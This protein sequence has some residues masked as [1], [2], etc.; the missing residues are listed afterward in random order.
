[1]SQ[2]CL[3]LNDT[4]AATELSNC[5]HITGRAYATFG[6]TINGLGGALTGANALDV[7]KIGI[8]QALLTSNI[9][10]LTDAYGRVGAELQIKNGI[11]VDGIRADGSFGSQHLSIIPWRLWSS[12]SIF[13][14]GQHGGIIYNGN[15]GMSPLAAQWDQIGIPTILRSTGKD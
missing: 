11:K 7:S 15:Y 6:E 8:D 9:S 2:S 10:L 1:M 5:T 13:A 4:L 12:P 3:L 14:V